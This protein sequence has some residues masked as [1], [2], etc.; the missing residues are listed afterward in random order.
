MTPVDGISENS[1]WELPQDDY[2]TPVIDSK[3]ELSNDTYRG[4]LN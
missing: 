3:L 1:S 4:L 2:F